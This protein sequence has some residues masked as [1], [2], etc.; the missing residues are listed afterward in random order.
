MEEPMI[1]INVMLP[2]SLRERAE[3]MVAVVRGAH[4]E[5]APTFSSIVRAAL[6]RGLAQ[7][8]AEADG[9]GQ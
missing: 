9:L 5:A 4:P 2:E 1:R 3:A 6:V 8:E 7:M